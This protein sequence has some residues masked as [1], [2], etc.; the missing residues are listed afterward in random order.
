MRP[1][2]PTPPPPF[3][4]HFPLTQWT[5]LK[6]LE[7][8]AAGGDE[9]EIMMELEAARAAMEEQTAKR[10]ALR[11]AGRDGGGGA[12]PAAGGLYNKVWLNPSETFDLLLSCA[13]LV[14]SLVVTKKVY[15]W[16][17]SRYT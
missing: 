2:A 14:C 15:V 16:P 3:A 5:I 4:P 9:D 6:G 13:V 10:E 1:P 11:G 12:D 17:S 7:S 8:E